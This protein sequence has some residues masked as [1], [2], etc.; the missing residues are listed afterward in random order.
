MI[1]M[2]YEHSKG[3]SEIDMKGCNCEMAPYSKM[4]ACCVEGSDMMIRVYCQMPDH[5]LQEFGCKRKCH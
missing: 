3:W 2:S 1:G 4:A 5:S